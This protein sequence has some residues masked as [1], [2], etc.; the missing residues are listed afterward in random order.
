[1]SFGRGNVPANL[2]TVHP[3][4]P[5]DSS[6][7]S[8]PFLSEAEPIKNSLPLWLKWAGV[9]QVHCRLR[10][11]CRVDDRCFVSRYCLTATRPSSSGTT[12]GTKAFSA[13]DR[14]TLDVD[15]SCIAL[16]SFLIRLNSVIQS[17][18][19]PMSSLYSSFLKATRNLSLVV[20]KRGVYPLMSVQLCARTLDGSY[21]EVWRRKDG[22]LRFDLHQ[23]IL[24]LL[25]GLAELIVQL[26]HVGSESGIEGLAVPVHVV[27][28]GYQRLRCLGVER[29]DAHIVHL[30]L[31][32]SRLNLYPLAQPL[33]FLA[34]VSQKVHLFF[35]NLEATKSPKEYG[36]DR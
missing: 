7:H 23:G 27:I 10:S 18:R 16:A 1:M 2:R 25:H 5:A 29:V 33:D 19:L 17:L 13:W 24:D 34:V 28:V 15:D 4:C 32:A 22:Q 3:C 12:V 31:E 20:W 9:R 26:A 11:D 14:S 8:A 21:R 36:D 35:H 30:A 6:R